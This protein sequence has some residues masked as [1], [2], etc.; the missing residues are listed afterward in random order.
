VTKCGIGETNGTRP[1]P[2][3]SECRHRAPERPINTALGPPFT[4]IDV[5]TILFGALALLFASLWVRDREP[6]MVWLA[7]GFALGGLWYLNSERL[8][9]SGP[10]M[11]SALLRRWGIV[12][13]SSIVLV[14]IGVVRYLGTP[15]GWMRL[16]VIGLCA[17]GV[18]L[19]AAM[20]FGFDA[21]RAWFQ[22]GMLLCY[23]GAALFAFQRH[24]AEP[25][26]GHALLGVVLLS[27]PLTPLILRLAGVDPAWLRYFAAV[28]VILFGLILLTVSLLRRRR[29]LEAEVERRIEAER[30][31]RDANTGLE[32]R[33][34]ERTAHLQDLIAG[35]EVFNRS[36]SH[37]LRGP[38]S[39]IAELARMAA[40]GLAQGDD[41]LARRA[42]P[43]IASQADVSTRLVTTLLALAR[44]E[45]ARLQYQ[46][47]DLEAL[48]RDAFREATLGA[49]GQA[50]PALA[51][52]GLEPL[53]ADADLL[54]P[55]L[56]N[57]LANAAKFSRDASAPQVHV[58]A[59]TEGDTVVVCVSD[60]GIGFDDAA[61][62]DLFQPFRRLHGTR[63]E[64]H[65]L[66]L[67]IVRRAI[68]RHGG[69]VW[70]TSAP[71]QGATFRFVIPGAAAEAAA[72]ANGRTTAAG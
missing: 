54:R 63:F 36:I 32:Q 65:G 21:P 67:S 52:E 15:K 58:S 28:P 59:T 23:V 33:V 27:L 26:A 11:D 12:I 45:D 43:M 13:G 57:L 70:A 9:F 14:T 25:G 48:V 41:A 18:A 30:L 51:C 60:N 49:R 66:G 31:L 16:A 61:A 38:L 2:R 7:C 50:L 56:V 4:A 6:G 19:L 35:L 17:P 53:F 55:A 10:T 22:T 64:G 39:G 44:L 8:V 69:R 46:W 3:L 34:R 20:A 42:L 62:R 37:D 72:Y 24:G 40:D 47:V 5:E 68:E 1:A 29:A 71:G